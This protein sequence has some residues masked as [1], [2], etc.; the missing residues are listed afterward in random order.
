MKLAEFERLHLVPGD[1]LVKALRRASPYIEFYA[2]REMEAPANNEEAV[3]DTREMLTEVR[4]V[5]SRYPPA[6]AEGSLVRRR[7]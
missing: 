2:K 7:P 6:P 3:R 5:L 4:Q 1:D